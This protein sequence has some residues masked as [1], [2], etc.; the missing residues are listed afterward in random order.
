MYMRTG[1]GG[2][3]ELGIERGER[4]GRL[5]DGL[6]VG[7]SRRLG[8]EKRLGIRCLFVHRNTHVVDGVDD[9][10]DLLGIDDLRRQMVVDLRVGQVTL[11]LAAGDEKF[12]L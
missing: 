8:G 1:S 3:A 4:S 6:F 9:I 12:E 11:L 10:L 7:R 5:L 2:A